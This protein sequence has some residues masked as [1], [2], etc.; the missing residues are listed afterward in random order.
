MIEMFHT[1]FTIIKEALKNP[2]CKCHNCFDF[3][4]EAKR[5]MVRIQKRINK[6]H[7]K[8]TEKDAN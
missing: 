7:T 3:R 4:Y 6:H 2:N 1:E 8:E 5:I